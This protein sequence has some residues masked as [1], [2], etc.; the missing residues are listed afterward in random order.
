M[1]AV[2]SLLSQV[3][4][5]QNSWLCLH[6]AVSKQND[7]WKSF[8][9]RIGFLFFFSIDFRWCSCEHVRDRCV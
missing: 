6:W 4:R 3:S 8:S 9:S 2:K 7:K 5:V 1:P